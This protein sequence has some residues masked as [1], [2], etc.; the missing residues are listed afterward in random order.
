MAET[1]ETLF[2]EFATAHARGERPDVHEFL[3]RAGEHT[4]ELGLLIDRHLQTV[5]AQPPDEESLV[6]MQSRLE[7]VTP[8]VAAR[9]RRGLKVRDLSDRLRGVLG[10]GEDL[11]DRVEEAYSD[12]ERGQLDPDRVDKRVWD[13][14]RTLL[15]LD[16]RRVAAGMTPLA[17]ASAYFREADS[18]VTAVL[19]AA[20]ASREP[21]APDEVDRL[22]GTL[23]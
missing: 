22:F 11:A 17:A 18:Q 20:P 7:H 16:A 15:D 8:L 19:A 23:N 1:V 2:D 10:L 4:Q 3:E 13:A 5:P 14:L 9:T 6:L 21:R 12:L